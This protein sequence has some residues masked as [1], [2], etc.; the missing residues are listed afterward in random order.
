MLN[1]HGRLW[2]RTCQVR[3]AQAVDID[4]EGE[5]RWKSGFISLI[6]YKSSII[7][8]C[9]KIHH[10]GVCVC[11]SYSCRGSGCLAFGSL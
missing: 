4:R 11:V 6:H 10:L 3:P 5:F 2:A 8:S 1:A 9:A 7:L